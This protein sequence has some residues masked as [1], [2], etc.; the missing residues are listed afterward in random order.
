MYV[1]DS[2]AC[3]HSRRHGPRLD[4]ALNEQRAAADAVHQQQRHHRP[5]HHGAAH[6]RLMFFGDTTD[7]QPHVYSGSD[8][9][10]TCKQALLPQRPVG[11]PTTPSW[12]PDYD[13]EE[14]V[15]KHN[16]VLAR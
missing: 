9:E 13:G 16:C 3:A 2:E 10:S 12:L 15:H 7:K 4:A 11:R 5:R 14:V 8:D 6:L 1:C